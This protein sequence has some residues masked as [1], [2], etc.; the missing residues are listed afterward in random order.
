MAKTEQVHLF[1]F[2]KEPVKISKPIR[3]IELFAGYGSQAMALKRL[4]VPFEPYK[5]V[6]FDKYAVASYNTVHESDFPVLDI[7]EISADDLQI[8]ETDKYC[9]IMTYSFP[10]TDLSSAGLQ[11]GMAEDSGTRSSLLWEVRRLIDEMEELPQILLMENVTQVHEGVNLEHFKRWLSFLEEKGYTSYYEDMNAKNFGVAQSRDRCF[12]V[13]ILGDANYKFPEPIPPRYVM[14]DYL[15]D[16][17]EEK[18]Y[19]KSKK[20]EELIDKLIDEGKLPRNG[21]ERNGTMGH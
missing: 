18:Y 10:C 6:E 16:D 2:W 15:E 19:L 9:Y 5:V 1:D 13:S 14:K 17:V 8:A 4:G 20:A 3:L 11:K 7:T 21:T 12:C